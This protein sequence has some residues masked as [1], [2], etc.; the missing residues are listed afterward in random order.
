MQTGL[1]RNWRVLEPRVIS[2][3]RF[4]RSP[5]RAAVPAARV[6]VPPIPTARKR[7][8]RCVCKHTTHADGAPAQNG[9]DA[10]PASSYA[11]GRNELLMSA[12]AHGTMIEIRISSVG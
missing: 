12:G 4:F 7:R 1:R 10:V 9:V 8:G 5:S 6:H 11:R 2:Y 3:D